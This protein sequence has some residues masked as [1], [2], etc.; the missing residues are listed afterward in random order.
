M[1]QQIYCFGEVLY[2]LL[3]EGTQAGGAPMNVAIHLKNFGIST[4]MISRVG[5]DDLG[6]NIKSFMQERGV[7]TDFVSTDFEHETG[8]VT[9]TFTKNNEPIYTIKQPAAWD[10]I[11]VTHDLVQAASNAQAIIYGSLACRT[12]RN[13]LALSVII[14]NAKLRI[15]DVNMRAPFYSMKQIV[16]MMHGADIVKMNEDELEQI[17]KWTI[18]YG[19]EQKTVGRKFLEKYHL[20]MLIVTKGAEGADVYEGDNKYSATTPNIEKVADTIGCGDSFLAAFIKKY[21]FEKIS[22]QKSLEFACATGALVATY[23]GAT[24]KITEVEVKKL[25]LNF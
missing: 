24:P 2:D 14:K 17:C 10:F 4:G 16:I 13:F 22:I 20:K 18:V 3:P 8:T 21:L 7:N 5:D 25:I 23:H 11:E 1:S 19:D 6:R 12:E 9:V 15:L